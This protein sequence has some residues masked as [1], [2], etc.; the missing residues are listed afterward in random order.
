MNKCN[1]VKQLRKFYFD[2]FKTNYL[3]FGLEA[4]SNVNT[5]NTSDTSNTSNTSNTLHSTI[6]KK[7]NNSLN[8]LNSKEDLFKLIPSYSFKTN[9]NILKCLKHI[10]SMSENGSNKDSKEVG[11]ED[12]DYLKQFNKE[13]TSIIFSNIEKLITPHIGSDNLIETLECIHTYIKY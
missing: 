7:I 13:I 6:N 1:N 9:F 4:I 8:S 10:S 11:I 5:S 3:N 12:N 2:R